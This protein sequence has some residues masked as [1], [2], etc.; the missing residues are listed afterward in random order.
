LQNAKLF[1]KLHLS[2][3]R[4]QSIAGLHDI[5]SLSACTLKVL[6]FSVIIYHGPTLPLAELR[7]E[8]EAMP[9][10]GDDMLEALSFEARVDADVTEDFIGS[11]FQIVE[12]VLVLLV[13]EHMM[14]LP[15]FHE[16]NY[17]LTI[18]V[19]FS[20]IRVMIRADPPLY[21]AYAP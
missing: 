19:Y 4:D 8:L 9:V 17:V 1:E 7:E 14:L 20:I 10:A 15:N 2:I 12:K 18:F 21:K 13:L 5:P 6:D 3:G 11:I 16:D